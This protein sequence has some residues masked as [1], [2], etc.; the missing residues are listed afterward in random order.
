MEYFGN[1]PEVTQS[2]KREWKN[3]WK[4]KNKKFS[5]TFEPSIALDIA[6]AQKVKTDFVF[7]LLI[8]VATLAFAHA[9]EFI[10]WKKTLKTRPSCLPK[11]PAWFRF[12]LF[13]N[14]LYDSLVPPKPWLVWGFPGWGYWAVSPEGNKNMQDHPTDA[15]PGLSSMGFKDPASGFAQSSSSKLLAKSSLILI[16][17]KGF[18]R[19][20]KPA[21]LPS[22]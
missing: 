13:V 9:E 8:C 21:Y 6:F 2:G 18:W 11:L 15:C 19:K 14:E 17:S 1:K 3:L 12:L 16:D 10:A 20:G 5:P 4:T 22:P 7:K